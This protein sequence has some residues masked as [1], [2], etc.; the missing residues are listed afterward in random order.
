MNPWLTLQIV[1][2]AIA[3]GLSWGLLRATRRLSDR[4]LV[5]YGLG[6]AVLAMLCVAGFVLARVWPAVQRPSRFVAVSL[7]YYSGAFWLPWA[8]VWTGRRAR[9]RVPRVMTAVALVAT[10]V[11]AWAAFI[12][13]HR[14]RVREERVVIAG[15]SAGAA[16][17]RVVHLSDLQTVGACARERNAL[18]LVRDANPD[19]IVFTGDYASG[20]FWNETPAFDA[21]RRFLAGLR[22]RLGVVVVSGHSE[23]GDLRARLVDGLDVIWL[24]DSARRFDL[25]D[26][27]GLLV[28]GLEVETRRL[29]ATPLSGR[30]GDAVLVVSHVPDVTRDINGRRV[31][32]HFAG[33]THGGQIA[34]P[35]FGPLVTLSKLP[36]RYGRGLHRYGDHWIN[37]SAGI[38]MEGGYAPRVRLFCPPEICI[39][40]LT[41]PR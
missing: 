5:R 37:V 33:H 23:P 12:E 13:P 28:Y 19:L 8:C 17:I 21:A 16:P 3:A 30:E 11:A 7:A 1:Q 31:D 14:L 22:A 39:L 35:G 38:G 27:R 20:P 4:P 41:G 6:L 34:I 25:G 18:D 40:T 32:V 26:G 10:G 9:R 29:P 36:R 15:W 2:A 24:R